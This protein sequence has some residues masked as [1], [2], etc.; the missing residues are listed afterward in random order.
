MLP[1]MDPRQMEKM[2]RQ[3]GIKSK[4]IESSLVTIETSEGKIII[5]NPQITEIEMQGQKTYQIAGSVQFES[6]IDDVK[7]VMEQAGCTKEEATEAL[8]KANG[9]IAHA[10][11]VLGEQNK[12]EE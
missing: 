1:G 3:M 4:P 12:K 8:K 6:A 2:M 11:I 10:I 5:T 9:D 7:L